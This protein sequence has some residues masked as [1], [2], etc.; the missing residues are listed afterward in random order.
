MRVEKEVQVW[1]LLIKGVGRRW[2]RLSK[3]KAVYFC[4]K[5]GRRVGGF[6]TTAPQPPFPDAEL[7]PVPPEEAE[8][9]VRC[10][11]EYYRRRLYELEREGNYAAEMRRVVKKKLE[12]LGLL[13]AGQ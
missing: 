8:A 9:L 4:P 1:L 12:E 7:L 5:N 10:A 11:V 13:L 3:L 2:T 6:F